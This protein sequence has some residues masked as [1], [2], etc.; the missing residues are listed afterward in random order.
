MSMRMDPH[1]EIS[2]STGVPSERV[3]KAFG[4][5]NETNVKLQ[6]I[7]GSS[8]TSDQ[9][10]LAL[11]NLAQVLESSKQVVMGYSEEKLALLNEELTSNDA[12]L[13]KLEEAIRNL[14]QS[15]AAIKNE[16]E[17][18][19]SGTISGFNTTNMQPT[20]ESVKKASQSLNLKGDIAKPAEK[21]IK[22]EPQISEKER[23]AANESLTKVHN[24]LLGKVEK[25]KGAFIEWKGSCTVKRAKKDFEKLLMQAS[26][27]ANTVITSSGEEQEEQRLNELWSNKIRPILADIKQWMISNLEVFDLDGRSIQDLKDTITIWHPDSIKME[28]DEKI[29]QYANQLDIEIRKT[30][31]YYEKNK[32]DDTKEYITNEFEEDIDELKGS[33]NYFINKEITNN[34]EKQRLERLWDSEIRTI[35]NGIEKWMK[36]SENLG[37]FKKS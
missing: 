15:S 3:Q 16:V 17:T 12:Q 29:K 6:N 27:K 19:K 31:E 26:K 1:G 25:E 24:H 10:Q 34:D 14:K 21:E 7:I 11:N 32:G 8:R 35:R 9:K 18:I 4:T 23:E 5:F 22:I 28:P 37:V 36:A 30:M 13:I 2:R 20:I 33:K